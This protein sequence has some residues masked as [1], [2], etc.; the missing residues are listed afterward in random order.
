MKRTGFKQK[1]R[2]PMKRSKLKKVSKMPISLLQRKI[3]ELCK[4]ITRAKHGNKCYTCPKS[5]LVGSDWHTGHMWAKA[6]LPAC[7]KYDLRV[8]RP[9][10]YNCNINKGGMGADFY[11]RMLSEIGQEEMDKLQVERQ[12]L[13]N[14]YDHY[15]KLL[16]EYKTL[17]ESIETSS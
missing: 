16:A 6:S 10:C 17:C 11:K 5:G 3:W 1:A 7:L 13:V 8:L 2:K 15:I 4:Q 9:Q 12:K 14:A